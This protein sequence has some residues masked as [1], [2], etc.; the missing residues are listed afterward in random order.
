MLVTADKY[1][2]ASHHLILIENYFHPQNTYQ[3]NVM[4]YSV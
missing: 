4:M 1:P 3:I 2:A